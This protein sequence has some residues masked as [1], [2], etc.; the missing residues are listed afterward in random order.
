MFE[1]KLRIKRTEVNKQRMLAIGLF[2][3][4]N[5]WTFSS[6]VFVILGIRAEE[7][8]FGFNERTF[9]HFSKRYPN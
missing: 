5:D 9:L 6:E 3:I 7:L 2:K 4:P 8:L 1:N